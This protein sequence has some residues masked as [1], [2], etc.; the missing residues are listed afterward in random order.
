MSQTY[1]VESDVNGNVWLRWPWFSPDT[2]LMEITPTTTNVYWKDDYP[3]NDCT[4]NQ[5]KFD[6]DNRLWLA[7]TKGIYRRDGQTWT[8]FTK[9]NSGLSYNNVNS[10][11]FDANNRV[12]CGTNGGGLFLFD[13]SNWSNYTTK[14]SPRPSDCVGAITVDNNNIVLVTPGNFKIGGG[15][16]EGKCK[17]FTTNYPSDYIL[18]SGDL[19]VTMTDLSK[20]SD[21]LGYGALVPENKS[22][23]YLG[24]SNSSISWI[25]I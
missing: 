7:T 10:L 13:G 19:I 20:E 2:C 16:Q 24:D 18:N 22:R 3:F 17:Y 6:R 4:V 11:A 15:F 9:D 21:T 8:A 14:N 23:I 12:W 1:Q 5:I 25:C